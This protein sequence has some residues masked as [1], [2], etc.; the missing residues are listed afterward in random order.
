MEGLGLL[1]IMFC[2]GLA[3]GIIGRLKGG[4]FLMW[5]MISGLIPFVGLLTAIALLAPPPG[6]QQ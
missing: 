5:F 1:V 3:G 6:E 4:S 2:F